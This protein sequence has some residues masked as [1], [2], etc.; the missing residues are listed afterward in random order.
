MVATPAANGNGVVARPGLH[1][2]TP[3]APA[4]PP[5]PEARPVSSPAPGPSPLS[6]T[7]KSLVLAIAAIGFL[8]DT[9]ELLMLPVIARPALSELLQVPAN[10][11]LIG[12]WLGWMLWSSAVSGGV[13]G[14]LGGFLI[15][16]FGRKRVMVGSILL[17]SFSPLAAAFSTAAWM[18]LVFRCTT[19]IG[20]CVEF[21]AA[22]TWLAE[23]FED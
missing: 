14:L 22:I 17:Y 6:T 1:T 19:F 9:Y 15:D 11:P 3:S 12:E 8:F 21:V 10:N 16:R 13:F 5:V 4:P 18:L 20:I 23:L 7:T 2:L